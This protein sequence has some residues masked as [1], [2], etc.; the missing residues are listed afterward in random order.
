MHNALNISSKK[1]LYWN[2][3][4]PGSVE[5][6]WHFLLGYALP[7][8]HTLIVK[9]EDSLKKDHCHIG[10]DSLIGV[11]DCGPIMNLVLHE[12][13]ISLNI[14]FFFVTKDELNGFQG[15]VTFL[16]RWDYYLGADLPVKEIRRAERFL[17]K[18]LKGCKYC[19]SS[20]QKS[21]K[22]LILKRVAEPEYYRKGGPSEIPSFGTSRRSLKNCDRVAAQMRALGMNASTYTPGEHSLGCQIRTFK[23]ASVVVGIRGAEFVNLIWASPFSLAVVVNPSTMRHPSWSRQMCKLLDI[24]YEEIPSDSSW[25]ILRTKEVL[26][27]FLKSTFRQLHTFLALKKAPRNEPRG[28]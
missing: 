4:G 20:D 23:M 8:C 14:D 11:R 18:H 9:K 21:K 17:L 5:H 19:G 27:A 13:L 3:D 25:H 15:N 12:I 1:E 24:R 16:P 2:S 26:C 28:N 7:L 22:I 6:Y 10:N